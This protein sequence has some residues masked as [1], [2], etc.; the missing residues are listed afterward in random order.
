[1]IILKSTNNTNMFVCEEEFC[2]EESTRIWASPQSRIADLCD[3]HYSEA[4]R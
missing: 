1:M 3:F 4:M 2:E